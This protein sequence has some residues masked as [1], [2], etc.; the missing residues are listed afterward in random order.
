MAENVRCNSSP[1]PKELIM[2]TVSNVTLTAAIAL[3]AFLTWRAT[4]S[5][6]RLT[7]LSVFF[8]HYTRILT[9]GESADRRA[10]IDAV[11]IMRSEFPDI[12]DRLKDRICE[13]TRKQIET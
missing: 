3:F 10:S 11:K 4:R 5:Y 13:A 1:Q 2:T 7:C 9:L 12:Y 6:A 8:E